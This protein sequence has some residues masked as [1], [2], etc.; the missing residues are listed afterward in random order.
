MFPSFLVGG[1]TGVF[2]EGGIMLRLYCSVRWR[3]KVR[4]IVIH[5]GS[6]QR[7]DTYG[8]VWMLRGDLW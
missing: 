6:F 1:Y 2:A 7:F 5:M 3:D 8:E 4:R